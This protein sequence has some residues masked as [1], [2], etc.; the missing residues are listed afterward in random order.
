MSLLSDMGT[1]IKNKLGLK[2]NLDSPTFTGNVTLPSTTTIGSAT[3]TEVSYIHGVTSAIQTQLGSKQATLVSQNNIK[4][5]NGTSLLGSGDLV[6]STGVTQGLP[7]NSQVFTSSG[8]F[9]VPAG[10]TKIR[11]VGCGGGGGGGG[12]E[13][14]RAHV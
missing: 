1:A 9:T 8:T 2:A 6:I 7:Q 4:S 3:S 14:G 11:V 12:V 13:I 5:V 10:I